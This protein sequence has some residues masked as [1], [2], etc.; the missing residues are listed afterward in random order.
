MSIDIDR[1]GPRELQALITAAERRKQLISQRRP[2]AVVRRELVARAKAAG[3][4]PDEL[5]GAAEDR[6]PAKPRRSSA[7]KAARVA[8]KYRDPDNRRNTWSGRGRVPRWLAEKTRRG[9][10]VADFL[11][12]GLAR[13][14]ARKASV[15]GR[16]SVFKK[17]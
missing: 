14:T 4:T 9:H 10:S 1:L 12:P 15:I 8:P 3:Y 16:K 2:I 6:S 17:G 11:I 7:R 5:F 13:P